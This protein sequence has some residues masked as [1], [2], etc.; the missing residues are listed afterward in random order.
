MLI[1]KILWHWLQN[2][3]LP[4]WST[5][6]LY[7][8]RTKYVESRRN[9][10][11]GHKKFSTAAMVFIC[12]RWKW[13][14]TCTALYG[15]FHYLLPL[16]RRLTLSLIAKIRDGKLIK[17]CNS[18]SEPLARTL[19]CMNPWFWFKNFYF[20]PSYRWQR[21]GFRNVSGFGE[22]SWAIENPGWLWWSEHRITADQNFS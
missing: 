13:S 12:F 6:Q 18:F 5:V 15:Q 8:R 1:E 3:I 4:T 9:T 21:H 22:R 7:R 10:A 2:I 11:I 14:R 16:S 17:S 19:E 20:R